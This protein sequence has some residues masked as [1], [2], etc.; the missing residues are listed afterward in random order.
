MTFYW[1]WNEISQSYQPKWHACRRVGKSL[2][3]IVFPVIMYT[4]IIAWKDTM[5]D[6][7]I[8]Y[9]DF[10]AYGSLKRL[11]KNMTC[12]WYLNRFL[13]SLANENVTFVDWGHLLVET[14]ACSRFMSIGPFNRPVLLIYSIAFR[15]NIQLL[16]ILN[17]LDFNIYFKLGFL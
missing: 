12:G 5:S 13:N 15:N 8:L 4:V 1:V 11:D 7:E 10:R 9:L 17:S 2:W 14:L 6:W 3:Q 16:F